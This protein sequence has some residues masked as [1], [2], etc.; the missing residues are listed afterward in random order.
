MAAKNKKRVAWKVGLTDKQALFVEYY[1]GN[2]S[3]AARLAGYGNGSGNE[4]SIRQMAS[5]LMKENKILNAIK[6]RH[7]KEVD[8]R[9]ADRK[10]RQAFWTATMRD[11]KKKIQD[12]LRAS[13]LLGR[14]QADFTDKVVTAEVSLEDLVASSFS[15]E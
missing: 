11:T 15:D 9:I 14:S 8:D 5:K 13:E 4:L 12:R 6:A 1:K 10:E 3:E 7:S 2:A